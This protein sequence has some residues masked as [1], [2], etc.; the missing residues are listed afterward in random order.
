MNKREVEQHL[1]EWMR[2]GGKNVPDAYDLARNLMY[3]LCTDDLRHVVT[4]A[5]DPDDTCLVLVAERAL[6]LWSIKDDGHICVDV[7]P[8][9]DLPLTVTLDATCERSGR[10][11]TRE[12]YDWQF[13]W[14]TGK[15]RPLKLRTAST[16][17][18]DKREEA[19]AATISRL[20][21]AAGWP[22]PEEPSTAWAY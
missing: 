18:G 17:T 22:V 9:V 5:D 2:V 7:G 10:E 13:D 6:L 12:V 21:A 1:G 16:G 14:P 19:I 20:A 11:I 8:I 4:P 3:R 15:P